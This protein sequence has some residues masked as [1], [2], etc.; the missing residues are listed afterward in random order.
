MRHLSQT[1]GFAVSFTTCLE[2]KYCFARV[3]LALTFTLL[4]FHAYPQSFFVSNGTET[5]LYVLYC[6]FISKED[7]LTDSISQGAKVSAHPSNTRQ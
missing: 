2:S 7:I 4:Y 3:P 1:S 6:M 5:V